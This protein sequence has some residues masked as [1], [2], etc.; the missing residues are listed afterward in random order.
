MV[1]E[2]SGVNSSVRPRSE[3]L[4]FGEAVCGFFDFFVGVDWDADGG[5]CCCGEA[6][7]FDVSVIFCFGSPFHYAT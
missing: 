4:F 6:V 2:F 3:Q 7:D 5:G 1:V